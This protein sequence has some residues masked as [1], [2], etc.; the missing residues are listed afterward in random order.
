[1]DRLQLDPLTRTQVASFAER[2]VARG[3]SP[4]HDA[5]DRLDGVSR[6]ATHSDHQTQEVSA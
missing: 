3:R 6:A 1:M 5:L 4:A 2:Y